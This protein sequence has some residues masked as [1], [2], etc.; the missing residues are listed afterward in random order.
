MTNPQR[1]F[2]WQAEPK[3]V[4]PTKANTGALDNWIHASWSFRRYAGSAGF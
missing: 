1:Q 4:K 2:R 3:P